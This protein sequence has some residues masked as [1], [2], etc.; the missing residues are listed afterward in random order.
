[1]EEVSTLE[2]SN[3]TVQERVIKTLIALKM[4]N[5]GGHKAWSTMKTYTGVDASVRSV[6]KNHTL[7]QHSYID[8]THNVHPAVPAEEGLCRH[9]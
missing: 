9:S 6:E 3:I 2:C 1:M 5:N 7:D 4:L 8:K